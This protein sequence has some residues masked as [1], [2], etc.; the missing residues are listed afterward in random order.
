[1]ALVALRSSDDGGDNAS[2]P[3]FVDNHRRIL[4]SP[5]RTHGMKATSDKWLGKRFG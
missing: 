5:E 1:M 4:W 2:A 3:H